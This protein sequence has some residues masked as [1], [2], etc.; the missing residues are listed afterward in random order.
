MWVFSFIPNPN[1]RW[2]T[3]DSTSWGLVLWKSWSPERAA[4]FSS[5]EKGRF[6]ASSPDIFWGSLVIASPAHRKYDLKLSHHSK[7]AWQQRIVQATNESRKIPLVIR[8]VAADRLIL[9]INTTY[10]YLYIYIQYNI[11]IWQYNIYIAFKFATVTN[12]LQ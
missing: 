12:P 6:L 7:E 9:H 10:L 11:Y 2:K 1:G 3:S 4:A 8:M 5:N